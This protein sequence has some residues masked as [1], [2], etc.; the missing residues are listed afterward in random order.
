MFKRS[1]AVAPLTQY[2]GPASLHVVDENDLLNELRVAHESN[3]KRLEDMNDFCDDSRKSLWGYPEDASC[4]C[5]GKA[6]WHQ[7]WAI[8]RVRAAQMAH[9]YLNVL[10]KAVDKAAEIMPDPNEM[11]LYVERWAKEDAGEGLTA[12]GKLPETGHWK[13]TKTGLGGD[14]NVHPDWTGGWAHQKFTHCATSWAPI[15]PGGKKLLQDLVINFPGDVGPIVNGDTRHTDVDGTWRFGTIEPK[16][17]G[18]VV[19][20]WQCHYEDSKMQFSNSGTAKPQALLRFKLVAEEEMSLVLFCG[21]VPLD[22]LQ[23]DYLAIFMDSEQVA[24]ASLVPWPTSSGG[25]MGDQSTCLGV[26]V[27]GG[28]QHEI[29]FKVDVPEGVEVGK[30]RRELKMPPHISTTFSLNHMLWV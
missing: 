26:E 11:Q 24:L 2:F 1:K 28:K 13:T 23:N 8:H 20:G 3:K 10:R 17:L 29:A 14:K 27:S 25:H 18:S 19:K 9:I 12:F 6:K 22:L 30:S 4:D 5:P 15:A 21:N 16:E 7:G